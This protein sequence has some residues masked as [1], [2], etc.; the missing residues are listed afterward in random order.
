MTR[1]YWNK[2]DEEE[3]VK[4]PKKVSNFLVLKN[5]NDDS[6]SDEII[7][8]YDGTGTSYNNLNILTENE[9][10]EKMRKAVTRMVKTLLT[11]KTQ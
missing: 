10:H 1:H 3:T 5:E 7:K 9:D 8:V 11:T 4:S 6:S 2:C